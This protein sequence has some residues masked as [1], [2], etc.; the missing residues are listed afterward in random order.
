MENHEENR[1][2]VTETAA[3][4][5]YDAGDIA[6]MEQALDAMRAHEDRIEEIRAWARNAGI[7][8]IG[9]AHCAALTRE[10]AA[11]QE[12]LS[13]EFE[14]MLAG[15]KVGRIP[16]GDLLDDGSTNLACN[17]IGQVKMLEEWGSQLNVVIGLCLGHDMLFSGHSKVPTTTL[18][19]KDRK[20]R[21][22]PM[23]AIQ[24]DEAKE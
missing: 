1:R 13:D 22:N 9:I 8:R 24:R 23:Q 12:M 3:R 19:V 4:Y 7:K 15:C 21:H 6:I 11:V 20:Y 10:A 16:L 2:A 14:V 18:I 17:P 5:G